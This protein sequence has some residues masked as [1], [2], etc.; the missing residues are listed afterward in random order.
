[1]QA[2]YAEETGVR[3]LKIRHNNLLGYYIET[4]Q[5]QGE[6]LLKPPLNA[7]F[8]HRQTMA[9]AL[10]FTTIALVELEAKIASAAD[11]ALALELEA[12]ERLRRAWLAEGDAWRALRRRARRARRRRRAGRARGEA[13]LDAAAVDALARLRDRGRPPSG[14]RGGA[15]GRGRAVRRQR[16]RPVRRVGEGGRIAVVTGPNMAGK[17]TYPAPERADRHP[18]PDGLLRAGR[19]RA[20]RR[21]RP[22]LLARRRRRRPRPRPLDLHG[23][24][25]RDRGDPQPGDAALARHPR[26]DRP[27]HRDLRRPL[28]RLGL[29]RASARGQPLRHPVRHP[30]PRTDRARRDAA[31]ARQPH[32]AGEAS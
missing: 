29:R 23:R 21:R 15:E 6:A 2:R 18:R 7:T 19:A 24:D 12:F 1:M 8:I 32:D 31:A 27:R 25:G 22:A 16:L 30:L 14:G 26:R 5:A 28:D 11:R 13:R 4:P 10:R 9:G 20:Y 3:Q 17:S